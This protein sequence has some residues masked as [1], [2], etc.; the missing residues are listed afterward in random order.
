MAS[1]QGA[2]RGDRAPQSGFGNRVDVGPIRGGFRRG[3]VRPG[4]ASGKCA[5]APLLA[6]IVLAGAAA[7]DPL[8]QTEDAPFALRRLLYFSS[9]DVTRDNA[10]AAVGMRFVPAGAG[11][12]SLIG[13]VTAGSGWYR[14][15]RRR[16]AKRWFHAAIGGAGIAAGYR[17]ERPRYGVTVLAGPAVEHQTL[18]RPD[19][20]NA[21]EGTRVAARGALDTWAK[22]APRILATGYVSASTF[23]GLWY[24]RAFAG[25]EVR[26]DLFVGPEFV[27]IGNDSYNERRIGAALLGAPLGRLR[28]NL[29]VGLRLRGD[30][31]RDGYLTGG[32]WRRF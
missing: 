25:H 26:P 18:S 23:D 17:F 14:Y 4:P 28:G 8:R 27:G 16:R 31:A 5:L 21:A 7:A 11:S 3:R 10:Y 6:S 1:F 22:P 29:S 32:L 13:A 15:R 2:G 30:G 20:G 19:P 24:A 9:L 12:S